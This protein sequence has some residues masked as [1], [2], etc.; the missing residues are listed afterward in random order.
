M[1]GLPTHVTRPIFWTSNGVP[2]GGRCQKVW[3][4]TPQGLWEDDAFSCLN[5]TLILARN[6]IKY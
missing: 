5:P 1:A 2:K 6:Y 4:R 3:R